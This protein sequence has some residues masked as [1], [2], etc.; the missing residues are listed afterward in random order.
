M[1]H[2]TK[3]QLILLT[4]LVSFITS[5]ATGVVT[6]S[7]VNQ[8]PAGS[9]NTIEHDI[10]SSVADALPADNVASVDQNSQNTS[11]SQATLSSIISGVSKSTVRLGE[12]SSAGNVSGLGLVVNSRGTIM[13]DKNAI[14]GLNDIGVTF[15]DGK[16]HHGAVVES[17]INGDLVFLDLTDLPNSTTTASFTPIT[18]GTFPKLGDTIVSLG[19]ADLG[20]LGVGVIDQIVKIGTSTVPSA[21]STTIKPIKV[22]PGSPLFNATGG[23]I[24]IRTSTLASDTGTEFYPIDLIKSALPK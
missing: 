22:L 7:L 12:Y 6:V 13:T 19:G 24:G 20:T 1:E 8:V 14:A 5:I 4:L 11:Q 21:I 10:V 3:Q 15:S 2:L 18:T 16:I 9:T 17:Q 23:I